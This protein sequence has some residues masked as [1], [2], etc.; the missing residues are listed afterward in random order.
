VHPGGRWAA[1]ACDLHRCRAR[2]RRLELPGTCLP[3]RG[4]LCV[5]GLAAPRPSRGRARAV[6]EEAAEPK[7]KGLAKKLKNAEVALQHARDELAKLMELCGPSH[8]P[9]RRPVQWMRCVLASAPGRR[10][11]RRAGAL[12]AACMGLRPPRARCPAAQHARGG[13]HPAHRGRQGG[14]PRRLLR[15]AGLPDGLGAAASGVLRVRAVQRVHVRADV[16]RGEQPHR[17]PPGRVPH[18][19]A[20]DG[21]CHAGGRHAVRRGLRALL[22][23]PPAGHLPVRRPT[24]ALAGRLPRM[25]PPPWRRPVRGLAGASPCC[26]WGA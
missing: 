8:S 11:P 22:L 1:C 18:D 3:L 25:R 24:P 10:M 19:R 13:R 4:A 6:Q 16:P 2:A 26:G 21:L 5:A 12:R 14:L 9:A 20:R 17:A 15:Q 7:A 23:P